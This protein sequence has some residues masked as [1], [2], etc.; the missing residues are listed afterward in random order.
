M[1]KQIVDVGKQILALVR[2]MQQCK[3]DIVAVRQHDKEQDKRIDE[4]TE[5]VQQLAFAL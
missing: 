2:D 4:L 3:A 5:A 1:L